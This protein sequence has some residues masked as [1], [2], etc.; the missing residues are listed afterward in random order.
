MRRGTGA[1]GGLRSRPRKTDSRTAGE[2][3][4]EPRTPKSIFGLDPRVTLAKCDLIMCRLLCGAGEFP[5]SALPGISKCRKDSQG[6]MTTDRGQS[7]MSQSPRCF[8]CFP[9]PVLRGGQFGLAYPNLCP[10]KAPLDW[11]VHP[12]LCPTLTGDGAA[13]RDSMCFAPHSLN[14]DLGKSQAL[15]GLCRSSPPL[16]CET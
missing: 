10:G 9:S 12:R 4:R 3:P 14:P 7:P 8:S 15:L 5:Q 16:M 6:E 2:T 13:E 11:Q 1:V